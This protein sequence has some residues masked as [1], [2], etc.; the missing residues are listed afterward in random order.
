MAENI[1]HDHYAALP[2]GV[3]LIPGPSGSFEISLGDRVIFSK[4]ESDRFPAEN[5]VEEMLEGLLA[6]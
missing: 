3:H 5:E 1:L 4:E 2:G 6:G